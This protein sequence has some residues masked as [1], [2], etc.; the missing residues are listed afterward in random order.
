L[1]AAVKRSGNF[2][3][4]GKSRSQRVAPDGGGVGMAVITCTHCGATGNA[5]DQILG[6]QVRCS[7]CKQSF[8]AGGSPPAP[9]SSIVDGA[10]SDSSDAPLEDEGFPTNDDIARTSRSRRGSRR[11]EDDDEDDMPRR[12]I[13][14]RGGSSGGVADFLMFRRMA[15]PYLIMIVFWFGMAATLLGGLA[16]I[17]IGISRSDGASIVGGVVVLALGPLAV[18]LWC[19]VVIVVF[20]INETLTDIRNELHKDV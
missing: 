10:P 20:R 19:E 4:A 15:A 8:V 11:D 1:F 13:R 5:P 17:G 18:R 14:K 9:L 7:K 2:D 16:A 12:P 6:Q 3:F